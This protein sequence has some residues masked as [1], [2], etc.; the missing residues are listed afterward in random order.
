MLF[1]NSCIFWRGFEFCCFVERRQFCRRHFFLAWLMLG[2]FCGDPGHRNLRVVAPWRRLQ[3]EIPLQRRSHFLFVLDVQDASGFVVV[4]RAR[5]LILRG[6]WVVIL[7]WRIVDI[8][9]VLSRAVI[10]G[11]GVGDWGHGWLRF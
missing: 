9:D 7:A 10:D 11:K 8:D 5:E 2:F 1:W 4:E 3:L 6:V